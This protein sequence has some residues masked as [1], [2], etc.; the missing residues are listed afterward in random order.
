[1]LGRSPQCNLVIG[2]PGVSRC[3]AMI[4]KQE[5]G[6]WFFDLGSFNGSYLNGS[7]VTASR[8]LVTGD[9]LAFAGFQVRFEQER[10]D[11]DLGDEGDFGVSTVA[12]IRSTPVIMLVSDVK[13]F[14]SLSEKIPLDDLA[15]IIGGWYASC[16]TIMAKHGATVDKF[17]GDCVLSYWTEVGPDQRMAALRAARDMMD[18]CAS[19]FESRRDLFKEVDADFASGLALHLGEV[20]YG[21]MSQGEFTLL[22]DP[23]NLTFR[24]ESLTRD[25]GHSV[26]TS[27]D[28]LRDWPEGRHFCKN[29]GTHLIK[30]RSQGTEIWAVETFPL[31]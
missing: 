17:I 23:V 31:D 10:S 21:G 18:A 26:V 7:R 28:F 12:L 29:L 24:M 25:V 1:M 16:E 8:K 27:G 3:H 13:G 14:T 19:T 2:D 5:D 22:G 9:V 20:A 30:G 11:S 4:R 15:Q 6:F